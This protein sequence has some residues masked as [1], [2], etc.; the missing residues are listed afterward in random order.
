MRRILPLC[1][2]ALLPLLRAAAQRPATLAAYVAQAVAYSPL[3]KDYRRQALIAASEQERLT[4][5]YT[6]SRLEATGDLLFV[7]VV[8]RADGRTGF[9]LNA[10]NP[11]QYYGY[12]LGESSSHLHAGV[13]W[14]K[15]LLGRWAV[16][17]AAAQA[18]ITRQR[19]AQGERLERHQLERLV[20]EHYLQCQLDQAQIAFTDTVDVL[21]R[22]QRGLL[23]R[24]AR[25]GQAR[26]TDL[27]LIDIARGQNEQDR[28]AASQTYHS[29]LMELN[30]LC[31][32]TDTTDVTLAHVRP[33]LA[34]RSVTASGFSEPFRLDSLQARA[35]L[36]NFNLQ[37]RP[38]LDLYATAG[39]QTAYGAQWLKHPGLGANA[40]LTFT[41]T[42]RDGGQQRHKVYQTEQRLMTLAAYREQSDR[43]RALRLSQSRAEIAAYDH[44][45]QALARQLTHYDALLARYDRELASG[46][47]SVIDYLTVLKDK[48][49]AE[50]ERMVNDTNRSL[51]VTAYN[52]W[53]W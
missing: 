48:L 19:T 52:Y 34:L 53:N 11:Q 46:L 43:Q 47:V 27:Q 36:R 44:R 17:E 16:R 42:L 30:L 6:H 20:T 25:V 51:A 35:D 37:Y 24:L 22:R 13:T 38:R 29:H 32:I 10:Q 5:L 41:W 8:T 15:P 12:D 9:S 2:L 4:A 31:G 50:R 18:D 14:T 1:L 21:L 28:L 33:V 7:P 26:Q 40:G 3:I 23:A 45:Q 39:L 49:Q